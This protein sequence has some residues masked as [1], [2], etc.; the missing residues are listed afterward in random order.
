[1]IG[2]AVIFLMSFM[3]LYGLIKLNYITINILTIFIF[4]QNIVLVLISRDISTTIYHVIVI[5]KEV[6]VVLVIL[7]SF[8]KKRSVDRVERICFFS[9]VIL[10]GLFLVHSKGNILSGLASLRQLYLP[11]VFYFFGKAINIS[12]NEMKKCIR[13][14]I[15]ISA[16]CVLFGFVEMM[17]GDRF[18][19]LIGI[20]EYAAFK[21][22]DKYIYKGE[23]VPGSFYSYDFYPVINRL[24]RMVSTFVDPVILGQILGIAFVI[25]VF[26]NDIKYAK[27]KRLT[28]S[29]LIGTGLI[30][31]MAK[32]GIIIA[33]ISALM[34]IR[35]LWHKKIFSTLCIIV[36][37]VLA[38]Q[39]IGFGLSNDLSVS[40]HIGGL[41]GGINTLKNNLFGVGIGGYGNLASNFSD[42][43]AE[44]SESFIGA[45]LGQIGIFTIIYLIF[46]YEFLKKIKKVAE[47][48]SLSEILFWLNVSLLL[49][50]FVNNTAISFT[51]CYIFYILPAV[52]LKSING[53]LNKNNMI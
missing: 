53:D 19:A 30:L 21:G 9:I 5:I 20:K 47:Y 8:K 38:I 2:I 15:L 42:R 17:L 25:V 40:A 7:W 1:M 24:R 41:S 32:G 29:I 13:F 43:V 23:M 12:E 18:W 34:L 16:F 6:Y 27:S 11:F 26:Y 45:A 22:F 31:S 49:T 52:N 39:Y 14:F 36:A 10:V 28:Y 48:D 37:V 4:F 51:N 50:S 35:K 44:G 33:A 3:A 46:Y